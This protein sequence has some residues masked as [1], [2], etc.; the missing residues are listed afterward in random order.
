M[1]DALDA[2]YDETMNGLFPTPE[3]SYNTKIEGY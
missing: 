3:F 2:F 1:V